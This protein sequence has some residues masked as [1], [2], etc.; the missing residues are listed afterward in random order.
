VPVG[1]ALRLWADLERL[2][3]PARFL[4]FPDENHW[5]LKPGDVPVWY[6]TVFAFL[7]EHVL[8]E[9]WKQPELL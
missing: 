4:Y 9:T 3:K 8:G 7:A 1:E 2:D 6:E 5:I